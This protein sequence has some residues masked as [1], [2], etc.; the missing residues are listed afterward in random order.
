MLF[1]ITCWSN[2]A[3]CTINFGPFGSVALAEHF[4]TKLERDGYVD[5]NIG[6][7]NPE[8]NYPDNVMVDTY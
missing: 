2:R 1:F 8:R 6:C 5:I 3:E 7:L 4:V